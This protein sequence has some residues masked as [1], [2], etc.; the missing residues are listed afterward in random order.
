LDSFPKSAGIGLGRREVGATAPFLLPVFCLCVFA[1]HRLLLQRFAPPCL[2][3]SEV[4]NLCDEIVVRIEPNLFHMLRS[5]LL[6]IYKPGGPL[7]V[8]LEDGKHCVKPKP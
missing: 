2:V 6:Q 7:G 5:K 8:A 3:C 1:D 4:Q